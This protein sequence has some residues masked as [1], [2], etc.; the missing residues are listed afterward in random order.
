MSAYRCLALAIGAC[1]MAMGAIVFATL[2]PLPWWGVALLALSVGLPL[3]VLTLHA[4]LFPEPP[5][6][7]EA[8]RWWPAEQ[9]P[10]PDPW[11]RVVPNGQG[12]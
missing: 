5:P 6:P 11:R 4:L 1:L 10:E 12:E 9:S 7:P 2:V 8:Y 3:G